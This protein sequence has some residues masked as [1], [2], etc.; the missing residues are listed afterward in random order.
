MLVTLHYRRHGDPR[1]CPRCR[2]GRDVSLRR[3]ERRT[4]MTIRSLSSMPR[5]GEIEAPGMTDEQRAELY[6][7]LAE[8]WV[9]AGRK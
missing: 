8:R 6:A 4:V 3:G 2:R 7:R 1:R 9:G 5:E